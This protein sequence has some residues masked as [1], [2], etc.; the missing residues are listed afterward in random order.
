MWNLRN[1]TYEE[2]KK[3]LKTKTLKYREQIGCCQRGSGWSDE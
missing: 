2:R 1:K 3:D